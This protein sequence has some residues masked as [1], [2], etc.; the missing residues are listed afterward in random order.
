MK[1]LFV[2]VLAGCALHAQTNTL[3]TE[4]KQAYT[5]VKNNILKAAEKM[6]EEN[7]SFKATPDVRPF[8]QLIAHVAD[9]QMRTC[10]AVKGEQKAGGAASKTT[11]ADL[12][13]ALKD[14]IAEC[15]AAYDSVTDANASEVIKTARGQ[16]SKLGALVGNTAHDNEMYGTMSVYMRLKGI[17]PP[18]SEGR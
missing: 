2:I 6:P 5:S 9:A 14:S 18:S 15:D 3:T 13:A 10:S 17:V 12:L 11:K 1:N 7:Y 8:G 16:R 4:A